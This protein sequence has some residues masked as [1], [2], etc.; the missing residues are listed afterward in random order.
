MCK[1]S[2]VFD[3]YDINRKKSNGILFKRKK[4]GLFTVYWPNCNH[5]IRILE[6]YCHSTFCGYISQNH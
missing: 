1:F 2:F 5:R 3:R 4:S 6:V